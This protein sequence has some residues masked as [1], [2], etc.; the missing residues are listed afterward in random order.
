MHLVLTLDIS[1][2]VTNTELR[3]AMTAGDLLQRLD[4]EKS[5]KLP[6][7]CFEHKDAPVALLFTLVSGLFKW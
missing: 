2:S 7:D 6:F 1:E 5:S 3:R 4:H